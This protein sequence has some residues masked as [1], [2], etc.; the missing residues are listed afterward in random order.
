MSKDVSVVRKGC[1]HGWQACYI[2]PNNLSYRRL[3]NIHPKEVVDVVASDVSVN[4]ESSC[5]CLTSRLKLPELKH[6]ESSLITWHKQ[7]LQWQ[8]CTLPK[9]FS[10]CMY[11]V[12]V[13]VASITYEDE[14]DGVWGC[15]LSA[16]NTQLHSSMGLSGSSWKSTTQASLSTLIPLWKTSHCIWISIW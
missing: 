12:L 1:R 11:L 3:T 8:Q 13:L 2:F 9:C 10:V 5:F 14:D 4:L 15:L 6:Q 16:K 7:N